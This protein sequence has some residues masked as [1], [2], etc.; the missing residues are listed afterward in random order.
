MAGSIQEVNKAIAN[1]NKGSDKK[2]E[3]RMKLAAYSNWDRFLTPAPVSIALLGQLILVSADT[4]FSLQDKDNTIKF[5]LLKY[6]D[7][8]RACLMQVS[9]GNSALHLTYLLLL[10]LGINILSCCM[11]YNSM[12]EWVFVRKLNIY[13]YT[14][15]N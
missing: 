5:N 14:T 2:E 12:T 8:F 9:K 15:N 3:L 10:Y 11:V 7:S 6:P 13:L 4:D 1:M